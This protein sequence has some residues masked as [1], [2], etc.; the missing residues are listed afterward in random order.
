MVE[1]RELNW[2]KHFLVFFI[3]ILIFLSGFFFSN[4]FL[5]KK[6]VQ[7]TNLQQDLILDILSLETQFSLLT[8]MPCK[9]WDESILTEQLQVIGQKL[10]EIGGRL[11]ENNPDFIRFKKYYSI[12]EIKSWLLLKKSIQN[13]KLNL[14]PI[15]Y[16][17]GSEKEC[18]QCQDQSFLLGYFHEKYP[19]LRIYS[20]DYNLGLGVLQTLKSMYSL[21]KDLPIIIVNGKVYYGFQN[22]EAI[23][24]ILKE[25]LLENQIESATSTLF[26]E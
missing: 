15:F 12:L 10:S 17:Y 19:S 24:K 9:G 14:V 21:K 11:G 3:T 23:E 5:G 7:A 22:K 18:G 6:I 13:C 1:K 8:E 20:F 2:K 16:F 25:Y 26:Q 4:F